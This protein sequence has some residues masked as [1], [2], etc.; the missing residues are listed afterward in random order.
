MPPLEEYWRY[1]TVW[2]IEVR[3]R[4]IS[5]LSICYVGMVADI[6][7]IS[8]KSDDPDYYE[9]AG[10]ILDNN[11]MACWLTDHP[12]APGWEWH[13]ESGRCLSLNTWWLKW[14]KY[15]EFISR[16]DIKID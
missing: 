3:M 1:T 16:F 6:L 5:E 14:K 10:D 9:K 4:G 7:S 8:L 11:H 13:K 2:W 12:I 15:L